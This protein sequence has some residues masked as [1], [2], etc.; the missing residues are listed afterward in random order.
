[1]ETSVYRKPTFTGLGLSFFSFCPMTFKINGIKTL[2]FRANSVCS[3]FTSLN[4]EFSFLV[5]YFFDN[6]YPKQIVYACI[7]KFIDHI[8][9]SVSNTVPDDK[10]KL[11][12]S[13]PYF[14]KQSEKLKDEVRKLING[15]LP[16]ID[17]KIVLSNKFSIGS[18]F[19]FKERLPMMM[20]SSVIYKF[21]CAAC[22]SGTYVGS[23]IRAVH[24]RI[25]D[26]RGRSF[27]TGK[28]ISN[29]MQSAIREH[30]LKCSKTI[31]PSDFSIL[32]SDKGEIGLRIMESI[33]INTQKPSLNDKQSS[34]SL[35]IIG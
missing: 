30:S 10:R 13:I 28:L 5:N 29:P 18:L 24:M 35:K 26:H 22:A 21:S 31:S 12:V 25:A 32:G 7:N 3:T 33:Y 6:G 14:G 23:T 2:L 27:R 16:Q 4:K 34:F 15:I 17:L 8:T 11:Y 20:Q 19:P 1:M 9:R